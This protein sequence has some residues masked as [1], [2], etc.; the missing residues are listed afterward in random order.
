MMSWAAGSAPASTSSCSSSSSGTWGCKDR[1]VGVAAVSQDS[2]HVQVR[3]LCTY[4]ET[5]FHCIVGGAVNQA[6]V[7]HCAHAELIWSRAVI[8]QQQPD[9]HSV[10]GPLPDITCKHLE[11]HLQVTDMTCCA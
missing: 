8:T 7:Q 6:V 10:Q 4:S 9:R 11:C 1:S 3:V 2:H 5:T